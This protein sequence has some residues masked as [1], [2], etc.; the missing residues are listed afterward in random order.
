MADLTAFAPEL[1]EIVREV[2]EDGV[3]NGASCDDPTLSC[4]CWGCRGIRVLVA[5]EGPG[6]CVICGCDEDHACAP[7]GC[8]WAD[9]GRRVCD[10]HPPEDIA[11]ACLV[12]AAEADRFEAP[13]TKETT[14]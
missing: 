10:R 11:T 5:V 2:V 9:P 14:G 3:A 7:E 13:T 6:R 8:G 4:T 1:L 12:L